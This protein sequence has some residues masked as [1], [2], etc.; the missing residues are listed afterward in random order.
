[1][2]FF[3]RVREM[4]MICEQGVML[5]EDLMFRKFTDCGME[6]AGQWEGGWKLGK[7]RP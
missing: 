1:M 2:S 5:L 4:L 7:P 3:L 6:I